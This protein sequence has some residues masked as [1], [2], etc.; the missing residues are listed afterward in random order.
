MRYGIDWKM[1][2]V[3]DSAECLLTAIAQNDSATLPT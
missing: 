3:R 2:F 1:T